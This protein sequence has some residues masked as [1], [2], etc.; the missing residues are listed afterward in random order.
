MDKTLLAA[1]ISSLLLAPSSYADETQSDADANIEVISIKGSRLDKAATATG[2]PLTLRETPQS[3][4][5]IDQEFI[6]SFSLNNVADLMFLTPGISAQKAETNRYF[7]SARG[8]PITNFQFD[9]VPVNYSSFFNDASTDTVIFDRVEVVR[10]ATG[11]LTGAGEPSAAINLIR[12]RPKSSPGGYL[13]AKVGSWD[14]YRVEGDSSVD[15]TEDADV[16]ARF[17]AAYE[18]SDSFTDL[19]EDENLQIYGVVTARLSDSTLFTLG[20]DYSDRD[21]KG[22]TWGAL[23]L[24]Y[25]DGSLASDLPR[26]TTTAASWSS[27]KR[28]GANVFSTLE[29]NFDNNWE[30][31]LD[32]EHREDKMDGH[33]LYLYGSPDKITGLGMSALPMIYQSTR[34]QDAARI[35][36]SGPFELLGREHKLTTGLLYSKQDISA[37]SFYTT[38]VLSI[39]NFFEWDGSI[40]EPNYP[41]IPTNE[42]TEEI[43]KGAYIATQLNLHD[44]V[45]LLLG[46][47]ISQYKVDPGYEHN[48]VITPY[49]GLIY[50]ISDSVSIYTSYTEIFQPQDAKDANNKRLDPTTG[51]NIELGSK[52]DFFDEKLT[53][54]VAVFKVQKENVAEKD[55]NIKDPLPDGSFPMRAVDGTSNRG[56]EMELTGRPTEDWDL[57][58]SYTYSESEKADGS[59]FGTHLPKNLVRLSSLY[60]FDGALEDLTLGGN[61][62]WQSKIYVENAGPNGE[63]S[64]QA[65]YFLTNLMASY[66]LTDDAIVRLNIRNLFDEKYYSSIDFYNQGFFGEPRNVELSL[67]YNF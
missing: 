52:A 4:T 23:P 38:D 1:L 57:Y 10:G 21:P 58:F 14:S 33:L 67:S 54:S 50:D 8:N 19:A 31:K 41:S 37:D 17:A 7:F 64:E 44:Q 3:V 22:S 36:A 18:K 29:H 47:R 42:E 59:A 34:K 51:N 65:S 62:S 20:A 6:Q 25:A 32:I 43:Q 56:F 45:T 61:L 9:G 28:H 26:S 40:A 49:A 27:W 30:L 13:S 46:S 11:L 66:Q 60:H 39:G 53:A 2:L 5:I 63:S 55:P 35:F 24:F 48:D 15:I 12:K 16:Q